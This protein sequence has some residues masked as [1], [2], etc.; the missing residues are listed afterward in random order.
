[1]EV[2]DGEV[3]DAEVEQ[4]DRAIAAGYDQLVLVDLRPCQVVQSVVG[5][6][7]SGRSVSAHGRLLVVT[8]ICIRFLDLDALRR[9]AQRKEAAIAHDA[10]VGGACDGDPRVVVG[11]VLDSIRVEALSAELKH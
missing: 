6:E 9:Q 8:W 4:L 2:H 5:V 1:M 3:V 11:R 7:T 10:E